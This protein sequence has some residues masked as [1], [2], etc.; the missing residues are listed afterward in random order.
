M[1]MLV[2]GRY[3]DGKHIEIVK[4]FYYGKHSR[5]DGIFCCFLDTSGFKFMKTFGCGQLCLDWMNIGAIH[6]LTK[7]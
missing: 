3:T 5:F 4:A 6:F 2:L 7:H 1:Y